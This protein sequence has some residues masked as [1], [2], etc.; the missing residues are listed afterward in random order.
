MAK[1]NV[2]EQFVDILVRA[3]VKRMYGVVGDSLNPVVDAVRRTPGIDWVHVRHEETAAFAAGAE[4]QIT[5][6]LTACAGSCGPGNLHLING[7]YDAHRSMA[8][9][10]A[11]ASHIPSSEIGLGYFQETH[12]EL[13]F[14]ECSHYCEMIS[15]PEQMP[16]LLQTA[17]QNAIGQGGVSVVT[18][19][20]DIAD[21]P[22]PEK[23]IESALVT[24]RPSVRPGESEIA[25]LVEM[26]D[27][28]EKV[29]L[30]CGSGTA[31]AHDEVMEFA[32]KL[33]APVGHALRGKEW[34][35]YDNPFDVGMSGLLGYGAAYEA[36]HECDLLI[37]LGTDF[38]YNA[39]LPDDVKIAQVDVRPEHLGRRS[40]LDLAIWGDVRETLRCLTPLVR[41][42]SSRRFLDRMLKKHAEA[43]EGVVSAYTRKVDKHVP[44]H[45][46]YVASVLDDLAADDAVFTVDTGMNNV[47]AARYITPNG[48]RRVIGSFSHGSMAN[49]LPQAIGAQL[50]ERDRQVVAM[51]GDG[52]F[53][54]LMGDFLTLVQ[55]N[56]PVKVVLFNNSSLGMVEL[57]M[58]V[59][60][61]PAFGTTNQNPDFA[62]VAR[63][64]GAY[65]V[66]VEKPKQL[67]GALKDA[68]K[69]DGPALVDVVTD[70]NALSIPPKIKAEM[71]T[72]F[73]LSASKMVLDGGVGKMLQMARS[74]LRN[75]P[76]P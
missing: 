63:A 16:R 73:A 64:C 69:H 3:G 12:P 39:F 9:V 20:G 38:P 60:G 32:E 33:K 45:P 58:L 40:K 37:L 36:T 61:L 74:N 75:I 52:G 68:F 14:R 72:G 18:L 59:G 70:P 1:Q 19:P 15:N 51:A 28:A 6:Q 47:W 48:K 21:K 25:K 46:E 29:T 4:A 42:K 27:Q 56:L 49:A 66:R 7:L 50:P 24:E 71:V 41:T 43:L 67:A 26:I 55:L 2:A 11:L 54:M 76:R 8:P 30:F 35:E 23:S 62:A 22:A 17:I 44:I 57:E 10:L 13:L 34:I 5:G 31:G 65:G 53:S